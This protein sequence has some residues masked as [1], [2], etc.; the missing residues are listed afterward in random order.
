MAAGELGRAARLLAD[1]REAVLSGGSRLGCSERGQQAMREV[2]RDMLWL[3]VR[4]A[5]IKS[6]TC[7]G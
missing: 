1:A 6:E 3:R 5:M 7:Y 2:R 4:H